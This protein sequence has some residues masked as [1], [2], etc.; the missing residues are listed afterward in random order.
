MRIEIRSHTDSRATVE[1]NQ[2]ISE[3]RSKAVV[4]YLVRRGIS[5]SRLEAAGY[6]ESQLLNECTD[7]IE[8]TEEQHS[9]N[10]RTEFKVI[11]LK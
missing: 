10:R 4:K 11:Q 9:V 3:G 8:C 7:G 5:A 1:F 2:K 6:G